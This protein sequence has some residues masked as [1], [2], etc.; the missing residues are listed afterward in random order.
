MSVHVYWVKKVYAGA[1]N[2]LSKCT[3]DK[4]SCTVMYLGAVIIQKLM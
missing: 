4:K 2:K 1:E 3:S